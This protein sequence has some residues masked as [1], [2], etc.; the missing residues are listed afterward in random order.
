[1]GRRIPGKP[2]D[3][4]VRHDV[5]RDDA[6]STRDSRRDKKTEPGD[7]GEGVQRGE[8]GQERGDDRGVQVEGNSSRMARRVRKRCS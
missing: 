3:G 1:M 7:G 8:S 5:G 2:G 6:D 4:G